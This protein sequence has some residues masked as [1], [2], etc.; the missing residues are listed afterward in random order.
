[1]KRKNIQSAHLSAVERKGQIVMQHRK[2]ERTR[3]ESRMEGNRPG[4]KV[5]DMEECGGKVRSTR[6]AEPERAREK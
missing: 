3:K 1:M 6:M 4:R 5:R 2:R